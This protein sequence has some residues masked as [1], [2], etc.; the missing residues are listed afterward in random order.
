MFK[1]EA[2]EGTSTQTEV[3]D[4]SEVSHGVGHLAQARVDLVH[5]RVHSPQGGDVEQLLEVGHHG[6][7][8]V[9]R[10]TAEHLLEPITSQLLK[11]LQRS[12]TFNTQ[13]I[14]RSGKP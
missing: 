8:G 6:L 5:A 14:I 2:R 11:V 7:Q 10:G 13:N 12:A 1:C 4:V 9:P 3:Q